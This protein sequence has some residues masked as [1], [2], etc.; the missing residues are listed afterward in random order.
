[1]EVVS[2]AEGRELCNAHGYIFD[3]VY[4]GRGNNHGCLMMLAYVD[5]NK[6][7]M[8]MSDEEL[9]AMGVHLEESKDTIVRALYSKS[10]GCSQETY[11]Y[12]SKKKCG[13][14]FSIGDAQKFTYKQAEAKARKMAEHGRYQWEAYELKKPG[15]RG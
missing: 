14:S 9:A 15:H 5:D 13:V 11:I 6:R 10:Y 8:D 3:K 1:M 4:M 12:V 7:A 2:E